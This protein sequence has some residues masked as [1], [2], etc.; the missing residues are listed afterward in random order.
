MAQVIFQD[1]PGGV[2]RTYDVTND[3]L[4][5]L[6]EGYFGGNETPIDGEPLTLAE[7]SARLIV[8][9]AKRLVQPLVRDRDR[10][11]ATSTTDDVMTENTD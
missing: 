10:K 3:K 8:S 6:E 5:D 1:W 11:R 4:I 2:T 9:M 7:R